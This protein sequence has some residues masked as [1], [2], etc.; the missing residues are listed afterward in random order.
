MQAGTAKGDDLSD[1]AS[2]QRQAGALGYRHGSVLDFS[3][4]AR[5]LKEQGRLEQAYEAGSRMLAHDFGRRAVIKETDAR[6]AAARGLIASGIDS[7]ADVE[8]V[9]RAFTERGIVES[10]VAPCDG[11]AARTTLIAV[12]ITIPDRHSEGVEITEDRL[13]TKAHV[14]QESALIELARK[15]GR[16]RRGLLTPPETKRAVEASGLDFSGE[17]GRAQLRLINHSRH[18][19]TLRRGHWRRRRWQDDAAQAAG[20]GLARQGG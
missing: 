4:L 6:I 19:R 16:G 3:R 9:R 7:A 17:H 20:H 14:V 10:G 5:G 15:H 11:A 2:W 12:P 1:F 13:T 8:M 18:E